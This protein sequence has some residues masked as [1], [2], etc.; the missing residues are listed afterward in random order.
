L[1]DGR[2]RTF[3]HAAVQHE[4]SS[5]VR[6][7]CRRPECASIMNAQDED[8]NTALHLA[9]VAEK[10]RMLCNLLT[11]R[12]VCL[13]LRNNKGQT[14]SDLAMP[15]SVKDSSM[16]GYKFSLIS[17]SLSLSLSL[18][19]IAGDF[20]LIVCLIIIMLIISSVTE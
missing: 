2:G 20:S 19:C 15:T 8:G 7:A 10:L 5:V 6:Y 13:N 16:D 12:E 14:A 18:L 17:L 3:L 4:G 9:V 1:R 11:N